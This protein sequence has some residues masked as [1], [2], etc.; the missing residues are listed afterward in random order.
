MCL[1]IVDSLIAA[2]AEGIILGCTEL[3]ILIKADDVPVPSFDT[4][5]IHAVAAAEKSME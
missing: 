5:T 3:P 2:G 4:M 1:E